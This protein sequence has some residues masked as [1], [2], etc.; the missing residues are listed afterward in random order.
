M[1]EALV[2]V[3]PVVAVPLHPV[4]VMHDVE[5]MVVEDETETTCV[6]EGNVELEH[7]DAEF[8]LLGW[9]CVVLLLLGS[10]SEGLGLLGSGSPVPPPPPPQSMR[11][12]R[13]PP[14]LPPPPNPGGPQPKMHPGTMG[15][16]P[17]PIGSGNP[18]GGPGGGPGNPGG[19][20]G[21]VQIKPPAV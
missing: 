3:T 15:S 7:D 1:L 14:P 2:V 21:T 5:V 17:P 12:G 10:L 8:V 11:H 20:V 19:R 6:Q 4:M 13:P 9:L 16:M 18:G